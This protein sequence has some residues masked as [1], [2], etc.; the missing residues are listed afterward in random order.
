[1]YLIRDKYLHGQ[2]DVN[3][4]KYKEFLQQQ[5]KKQGT[6]FKMNKGRE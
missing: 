5:Q 4:R 3:T 2:I 6:Q 1:M